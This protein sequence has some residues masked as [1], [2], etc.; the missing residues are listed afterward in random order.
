MVDQ[1]VRD[2]M[3]MEPPE[4]DDLGGGHGRIGLRRSKIE[5]A[6]VGQREDQLR[7]WRRLGR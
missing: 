4:K 1:E 6:V 7:R 3:V 2:C 5:R